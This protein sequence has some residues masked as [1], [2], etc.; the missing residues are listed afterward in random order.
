MVVG[1]LLNSNFSCSPM[2]T[3]DHDNRIECSLH[4]LLTYYHHLHPTSCPQYVA[5]VKWM[6]VVTILASIS[7]H[8]FRS[9]GMVRASV[10][11]KTENGIRRW[12]HYGVA[13]SSD[14]FFQPISDFLKTGGNIFSFFV[15]IILY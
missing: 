11:E 3:I 6:S 2:I 7:R 5:A 1:D 8:T 12:C 14:V 10:G 9:I 4:S 15:E 13:T